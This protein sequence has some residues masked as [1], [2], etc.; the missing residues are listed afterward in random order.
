MTKRAQPLRLPLSQPCLCAK[1]QFIHRN[2]A[3]AEGA[4]RYYLDNIVCA[5]VARF[6]YGTDCVRHYNPEDREH[7]VRLHKICKEPSGAQTVPDAFNA[8]L[9]KV[10]AYPFLFLAMILTSLAILRAL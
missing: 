8:I 1:Y 3:V 7:T 5:R 6:T 4:L 9:K 2:K 10:E